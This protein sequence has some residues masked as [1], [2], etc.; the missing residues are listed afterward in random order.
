VKKISGALIAAALVVAAA[1]AAAA[2]ASCPRHSGAISTKPLGRVWH[3][4]HSLFACTTVYG[5]RPRARRMGPWDP[6]TRVAFD[7]VDMAWTTPLTR[8]GVRSDRVWA[9]SADTGRRWLTGSRLVPAS[10]GQPQREARIQRVMQLDR[11]AAW[12]TRTGEVVMALKEPGSPPAAIGTLPAPL[13]PQDNLL[14][15]GS[16]PTRPASE[17]AASAMF[18][19]DGGDG[20]ECGGESTYRLTVVPQPDAVAVGAEWVGYWSSTNCS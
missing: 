1:P 17:L 16:W 13:D 6:K 5:H 20:D 14:L 9:G 11:G 10:G 4:G 2:G 7:G 18:T 8:D 3:S 12:V 19:E 15:V